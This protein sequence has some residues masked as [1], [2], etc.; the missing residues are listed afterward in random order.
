MK[1]KDTSEDHPPMILEATEKDIQEKQP[2]ND[3]II[4]FNIIK[5][6]SEL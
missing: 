2:P 1:E 3:K 4:S 5:D 6:D